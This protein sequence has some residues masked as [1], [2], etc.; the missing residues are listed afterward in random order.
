MKLKRVTY[1]MGKKLKNIGYNVISRHYWKTDNTGNRSYFKDRPFTN[2]QLKNDKNGCVRPTLELV[3]K[4]F[5]KNYGIIIEPYNG[6]NRGWQLQIFMGIAPMKQTV[7]FDDS[8]IF[9]SYDKTLEIG[10]DIATRHIMLINRDN[11]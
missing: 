8:T 7:I 10:I 3:K 1:T 11:N 4:W 2:K 5:R 9:D 6:L